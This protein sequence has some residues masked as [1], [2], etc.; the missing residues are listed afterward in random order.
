MEHIENYQS[1]VNELINFN[2]LSSSSQQKLN[3]VISEMIE[4]AKKDN[5]DT[6]D[7][8]KLYWYIIDY[9]KYGVDKALF[10]KIMYDYQR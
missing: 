2:N 9:L 1:F 4:H 5:F 3:D 6:T 8:R 10:G 7:K